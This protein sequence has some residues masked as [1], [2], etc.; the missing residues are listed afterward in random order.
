MFKKTVLS[1]LNN[2]VPHQNGEEE[3]KEQIYNVINKAF[4]CQ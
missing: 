4:N 3:K 1:V 2:Y